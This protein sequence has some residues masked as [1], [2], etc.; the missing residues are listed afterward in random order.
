MLESVI[1][2]AALVRDFQF[3]APP[4]EPSRTNHITLQPT[5]GVPS[6]VTAR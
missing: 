4:G 1:A 2:L 6:H 3:A 5:H